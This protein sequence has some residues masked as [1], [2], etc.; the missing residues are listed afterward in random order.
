MLTSAILFLTL[1]LLPAPA[2][3]DVPPALALDQPVPAQ[4]APAVPACTTGT[5][6]IPVRVAVVPVAACYAGSC[7]SGSGVY[8]ERQRWFRGRF[9][10]RA[11][12]CSSCGG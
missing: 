3:E 4:K 10:L 5:C 11:R 8:R 7:S 6:V 2:L 12:G 1:S 9:R